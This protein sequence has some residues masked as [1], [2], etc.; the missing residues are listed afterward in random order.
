MFL[1]LVAFFVSLLLT[2]CRNCDSSLFCWCRFFFSSLSSCR[3]SFPPGA[4][5]AAGAGGR[6]RP[7]ALGAG[8]LSAS[9][10][11]AAAGGP[12]R[13]ALIFRPA[14]RPAA[15]SARPRRPRRP[16]HRGRPAPPLP[17][18]PPRPRGLCRFSF[19]ICSFL[20]LFLFFSPLLIC[21]CSFSDC[22]QLLPVALSADG[23]QLWSADAALAARWPELARDWLGL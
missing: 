22:A 12:S 14:L 19:L 11:G 10:L 13:A 4:A 5:V 1:L 18:P 9:P 8:P 16:A 23:P 21:S 20:R 17:P 7:A 6:P 2:F 15:G 3:S